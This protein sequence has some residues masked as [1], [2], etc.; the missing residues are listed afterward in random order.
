MTQMPQNNRGKGR[1]SC[2]GDLCS[3]EN[4]IFLGGDGCWVSGRSVT[5]LEL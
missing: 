2:R 3:G 4:V 5:V 1:F